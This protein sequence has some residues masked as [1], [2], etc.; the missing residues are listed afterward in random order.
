MPVQQR[1]LTDSG[2]LEYLEKQDADL[3]VRNQ[4]V[5]SQEWL[6]EGPPVEMYRRRWSETDRDKIDAMICERPKHRVSAIRLH[7]EYEANRVRADR[8]YKDQVIIVYGTAQEIGES[9]GAIYIEIGGQ[10]E[11]AHCNLLKG[12]DNKILHLNKGD[13]IELKGRATGRL[14]IP[15]MD[16]CVL[17]KYRNHRRRP[18]ISQAR[19]RKGRSRSMQP[20][21]PQKYLSEPQ[22][23]RLPQQ[24]PTPM[25]GKRKFVTYGK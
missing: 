7:R 25:P 3:E 14:F 12:Q 20:D 11:Y 2:I 9:L 16:E 8:E 21:F 1:D 15:I 5:H 24:T 13:Y 4:R 17:N 22:L 10:L 18:Q 19:S 23:P 6:Q